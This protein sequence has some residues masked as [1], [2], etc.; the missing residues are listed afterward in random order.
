MFEE[1]KSPPVILERDKEGRVVDK[2]GNVYDERGN[3][4]SGKNSPLFEE[5]FA[6]VKIL[7]PNASPD[8]PLVGQYMKELAKK[9]KNGKIRL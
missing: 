9:E 5:A 2:E 8:D 4:I 1:S 7:Y 6:R 3:I